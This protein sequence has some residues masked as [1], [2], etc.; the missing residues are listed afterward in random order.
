MDI[1]SGSVAPTFHLES[2]SKARDGRPLTRGRLAG[3]ILGS[4]HHRKFGDLPGLEDDRASLEDAAGTGG[5]KIGEALGLAKQGDDL[6]RDVADGYLGLIGAGRRSGLRDERR[7]RED[8][9]QA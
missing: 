6:V 3:E 9:E 7:N 1:K 8:P 2:R 5:R 4:L